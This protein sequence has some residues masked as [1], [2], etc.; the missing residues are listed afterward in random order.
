MLKK[1]NLFLLLLFVIQ[2]QAQERL[3]LMSYNLMHYPSTYVY[4]DSS[5]TFVDRSPTL[6]AITDEIQPDILMVCELQ[7][8][9]GAAAILTNVL[10]V[11]TSRYASPNFVYNQSSSYTA[12]NQFLYYNTDKLILE[13]QSV[14]TTTIRDINNYTFLLNTADKATNPIY[15]EVF[16]AHL[17]ASTG[18]S[19]EQKR[20]NMVNVFTSNLASIPSNHHI[21]FAGDFNFYTASEDGYQEIIDTNNAVT[22]VDPINR[23]GS[24]HNNS[25]Y[26][27]VQTQSPL[28]SNNQFAANYG[29]NGAESDGVKG[30]LDDRFDFIM[31]DQNTKTSADLHYVTNSYKAFGNNGNCFNDNIDDIDCSG[32]EYSQTTRNNLANMSDHLPVVMELETNQAFLAVEQVSSANILRGNVVSDFLPLQISSLNNELEYNIYN[33]LGQLIKKGIINDNNSQ[34]DVTTLEKGLYILKIVNFKP[35]KFIKTEG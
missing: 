14:L 26:K 9:T 33:N 8:A 27:D 23:E 31:I 29:A 7:N 35:L 28:T 16:V 22:M 4:E 25:S 1:T 6:K 34:L 12:L 13:N 17:K 20:L 19:N 24:W 15:L 32:A 11:G 5:N 3:K 10:N 21:V 18:A 2:L 30:G